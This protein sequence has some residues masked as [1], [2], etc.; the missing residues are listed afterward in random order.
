[1]RSLS[2]LD[3]AVVFVY[4]CAVAAIGYRVSRRQRTT[5]DFFLANRALPGWAVAFS[6]IGTVISSVSFVALPGAAFAR[7]WRLLAPNLTV[8]LVLIFVTIFVVPFYRR[9]V[10][11]SSYEYLERR[12][13]VGARLYCSA[14]FVVLRTV[15]LAFTLLL[16][17]IAVEVITGWEIRAVIA[18]IVFCTLIYTLL[19]GIEAVV[20]NDVLQGLVLACGAL[21][22]LSKVLWGGPASAG[23]LVGTAWRG[24]KFGLGDFTLSWESLFGSQPT[25][26]MF[27][28]TGF[29]HF[30][31]SYLVEQNMVQR[32]LVAR[33]DREAQ[34]ATL[35]GALSCFAIWLTFS[36]LGSA[37]WGY[38]QLAGQP[39]PESVTS[40]PDNILPYFI[41][42]ALPAG[43]VG[44]ILAAILA[45]A[46][47]SF[48]ADL[49]SVA[50][51][52]TQDYY[53][54]FAPGSSETSRLLVGRMGL[55]VVGLAAG[56]VAVQLTS[57]RTRAVY[58]VFV[59]LASMVA[60]GVLGLFALGF[61]TRRGSAKG[62]YTGL[63]VCLLFVGWAT[64]TGPLRVDLG[65]NYTMHPVLIGLLS[66]V[67]MFVTGYGAS[68][69]WRDRQGAERELTVWSEQRKAAR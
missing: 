62:A 46:M 50:T 48:S 24:G 4:L 63:V 39:L 52:I 3:A 2:A 59:T 29:A 23:E 28:V 45:A 67:L 47:Q 38:Y 20:W 33:T 16:T 19:G 6:I 15:D 64:L 44:L 18:G 36:F 49:T 13:G 5:A 35:V 56:L 55:T 7:D 57:A 27:A 34:R 10:R 11:M 22:V 43:V 31:R 26:W 69:F 25:F 53:A 14:G 12:F 51:V 30:G 60:G 41:A 17:G 37:L 21:T 66:H 54:R 65:V 61:L 58:E 32:Y 1:M 8:P 42:T 9:V 40:Q 68:W